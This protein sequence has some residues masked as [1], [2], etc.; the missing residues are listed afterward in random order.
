[1]TDIYLG[2]LLSAVVSLALFGLGLWLGRRGPSLGITLLMA[3]VA[4]LLMAYAVCVVDNI[5]LA[6]WLPFSNLIIVG[7]LSLPLAGLLAGL[8]ARRL[9]GPWWRRAV[10]LVPLVA[11]SLVKA[12]RPLLVETPAVQHRWSMGICRQTNNATCTPAAAATLLATHRI[13]SD[14]REMAE[15]CLTSERG[16]TMWGLYRG[17]KRK[18]AATELDVRPVTGDLPALRAAS[19]DGPVLISVGLRRGQEADPRY[20]NVWGWMP[21]T[22]HTVVL[23]RFLPNDRVL[24]ADPKVGVE[25][26]DL[27]A[28]QTLWHG[29]GVQLVPRAG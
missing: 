14:E 11:V 21:G 17:L 10:L 16:T 9:P 3:V 23:L 8:G 28:L 4:G 24:I 15:L 13:R 20:A 7:N 1:M 5:A 22:M 19:A 2:I 18:T 6:R 29:Q 26:W 25:L 12:Y 27:E